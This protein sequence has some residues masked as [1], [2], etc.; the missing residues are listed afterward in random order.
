MWNISAMWKMYAK[1]HRIKAEQSYIVLKIQIIFSLMSFVKIWLYYF[2]FMYLF[3][4]HEVAIFILPVPNNFRHIHKVKDIKL[5]IR[6]V[7]K[8]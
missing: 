6:I 4:P 5:L 8:L 2:V 1:S 3:S 7:Y